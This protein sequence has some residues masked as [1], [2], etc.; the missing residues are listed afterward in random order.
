MKPKL[1]SAS[2]IAVLAIAASS[3]CVTRIVRAQVEPGMPLGS[4]PHLR[5]KSAGQAASEPVV[6]YI[7]GGS[8]GE[9]RVMV[10]EREV[11]RH[12]TPTIGISRTRPSAMR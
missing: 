4:N 6:A 1:I 2:A 7:R 12:G 10:G 3:I 5:S 9:V 8:A 11:V